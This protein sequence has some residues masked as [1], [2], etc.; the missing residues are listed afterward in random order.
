MVAQ[1]HLA[2]LLVRLAVDLAAQQ[3]LVQRAVQVA[4]VLAHRLNHRL[5]VLHRVATH[6]LAGQAITGQ[7]IFMPVVVA[8]QQR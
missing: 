2:R 6:L 3:M 7:I 8:V 4:E 5:A 1:P